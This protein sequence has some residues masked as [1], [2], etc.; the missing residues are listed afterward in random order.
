MLEQLK[1][2]TYQIN[3]ES[4]IYMLFQNICPLPQIIYTMYIYPKQKHWLNKANVIHFIAR[5]N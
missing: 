5:I 2:R 4:R 3:L 1:K